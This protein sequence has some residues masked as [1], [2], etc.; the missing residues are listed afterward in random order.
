MNSVKE[1]VHVR[2]AFVLVLMRGRYLPSGRL[3]VAGFYVVGMKLR[4]RMNKDGG[5]REGQVESGVAWDA[6]NRGRLIA[7][8]HCIWGGL[9][10]SFLALAAVRKSD[11]PANLGWVGGSATISSI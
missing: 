2:Q 10:A 5:V 4:V 11:R 1:K 9:S 8:S 7:F 3:S 6:L